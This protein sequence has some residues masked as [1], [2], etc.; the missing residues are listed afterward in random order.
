MHPMMGICIDGSKN[1]GSA[2][3]GGIL[4]E[5]CDPGVHSIRQVVEHNWHRKYISSTSMTPIIPFLCR[6]GIW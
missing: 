1:P 2:P 6:Y 5:G 3:T 4:G